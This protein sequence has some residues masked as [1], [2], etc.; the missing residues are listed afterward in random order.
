MPLPDGFRFGVATSGFQIEGG[1]NGPATAPGQ[2]ANNWL[3]WERSG[4]VAPAGRALDFWN[5][6]EEFLD[7]AAAAGCTAFR[8]SVE[9]ARCEPEAGHLDEAAFARYRAILEAC[10]E[11]G[12]E[13]VVALHHF[14]HPRWLGPDLWLHLQSPDRFAAWAGIAVDRLGDRCR[15]W[16][17]IN[18]INAVA[19]QTYFTGGLPPGRLGRTGD[20]VR[21]LAHLLAGHVLAYRAIHRRQPDAVVSTNN[22]TLSVYELDRLLIDLLLGRSHGVARAD[23]RDW[24]VERREKFH[25]GLP[26]PSAVERAQ[27]VVAASIIRYDQPFPRAITELYRGPD[28]RPIDAVLLNYY[29][30]VAAHRVWVPGRHTVGGR[31]WSPFRQLWDSAVDPEGLVRYLRLNHEPGLDLWVAEN[32]LCTRRRDGVTHRRRDGWDRVRALRAHLAAVEQAVSQGLPVTRYFHWTLADCYE[33][34]SFEHRFGLHRVDLGD[35]R[36]V[37]HDRDCFGGDAA[38]TLRRLAAERVGTR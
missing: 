1:Y 17:T 30:P 24:L 9:W 15:H 6:Y 27:R 28:E 22:H 33:W 19:F 21:A 10:H 32:G 18:E 2:P 14:T 31:N 13:P 29:D 38:G 7:R 23:L 36:P 34:G 35:G 3:D 12:L 20:A 4:R 5:R 25:A 16:L 37:W 8:L 11:R 26:A